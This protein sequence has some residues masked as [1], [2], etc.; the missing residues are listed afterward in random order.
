MLAASIAFSIDIIPIDSSQIE[1]EGVMAISIDT[2]MG[3]LNWNIIL[4]GNHNQFFF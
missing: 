2:L 1:V 4:E 3:T